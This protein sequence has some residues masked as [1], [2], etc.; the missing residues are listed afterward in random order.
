MQCIRLVTLIYWCYLAG[1]YLYHWVLWLFLWLIITAKKISKNIMI[2]VTNVI[3]CKP[4]PM[5]WTTT[6]ITIDQN[7]LSFCIY[8]HFNCVLIKFIDIMSICTDLFLC[9]YQYTQHNIPKSSNALRMKHI[10]PREAL[11]TITITF[12]INKNIAYAS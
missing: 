11:H 9:P 6:E 10:K 7:N 3:I 2:I 5:S 4:H 8:C 1:S 12:K